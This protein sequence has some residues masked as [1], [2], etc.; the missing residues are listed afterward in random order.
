MCSGQSVSITDGRIYVYSPHAAGGAV[1]FHFLSSSYLCIIV[2][3]TTSVVE[4]PLCSVDGKA[5]GL[6]V[7]EGEVLLC[8]AGTYP[9][10]DH[11]RYS[12]TF[13]IKRDALVPH[14]KKS[15]PFSDTVSVSFMLSATFS[16][17]R[18]LLPEA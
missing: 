10:A 9:D 4:G 15:E 5:S 16:L 13:V 7:F 17:S 14:R 3:L 1:P 2:L 6:D 18:K 8:L 12:L 11:A